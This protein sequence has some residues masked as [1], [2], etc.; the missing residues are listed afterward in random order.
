MPLVRLKTISTSY[1]SRIQCKNEKPLK[2]EHFQVDLLLCQMRIWVSHHTRNWE[3][4]FI[5]S[6]KSSFCNLSMCKFYFASSSLPWKPRDNY[7]ET[8]KQFY[9]IMEQFPKSPPT[10][11][12]LRASPEGHPVVKGVKDEVNDPAGKGFDILSHQLGK[13]KLSKCSHRFLLAPM[14]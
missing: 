12:E 5:H 3:Y 1:R 13:W 9:K 2:S 8:K 11:L 7:Q 6:S 4:F 14:W 10:G